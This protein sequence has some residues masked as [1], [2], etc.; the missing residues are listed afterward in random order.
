MCVMALLR[1]VGMAGAKLG[2]VVFTV[3]KGKLRQNNRIDSYT[4]TLRHIAH[5]VRLYRA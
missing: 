3:T 1:L 4:H 5:I 2:P